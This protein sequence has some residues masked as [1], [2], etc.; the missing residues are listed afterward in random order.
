MLG[1][2]AAIELSAGD[3]GYFADIRNRLYPYFLENGV[4]LRPLGNVIYMVPPYVVSAD[5]LHYIY[6][7]IKRAV[8]RAS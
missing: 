8:S 5:D 7:V 2:I 3:Q 4:L 1:T 6:D